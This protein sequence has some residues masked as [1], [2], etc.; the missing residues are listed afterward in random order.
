MMADWK[1]QASPEA[2]AILNRYLALT[3]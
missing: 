1:K 3:Q 2:V